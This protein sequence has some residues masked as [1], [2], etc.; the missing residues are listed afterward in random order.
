M[1]FVTFEGIEGSGKSSIIKILETKLKLD[2]Q[3]MLLREPGGN[4]LSE[5]LRQLI[6]SNE[7]QFTPLSETFLFFASQLQNNH[8]MSQQ[9]F[10]IVL[11]DRYFDSTIVYDGYVKGLG[12]D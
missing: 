11:C 9:Q 12:M 7:G 2:Y 6:I 8:L 3:V 5:V 10:Q 4:K 1:I